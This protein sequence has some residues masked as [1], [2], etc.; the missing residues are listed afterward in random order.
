MSSLIE[1]DPQPV[2]SSVTLRLNNP[3]KRNALS[4]RMRDELSDALDR[5]AAD[6]SVKSVVIVGAGTSFCSGFDLGEFATAMGDP[7]FDRRLWESS[8]RFHHRLLSFPLPLFAAVN[9]AAIAGGFDLAICCDVRIAARSSRFSHP[10]FSYGDILYSP[11]REL[12]GGAV[13]RELALTG[14]ELSAREAKRLGVVNHVVAD[15]HLDEAIDELTV[16]TARA[17]R[18][19]LM[20]TK[21]KAIRSA[22]VQLRSTLDL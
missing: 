1:V 11:L 7:I 8:D 22:G 19:K 9:G 2:T 3:K 17:P 12:V 14:R 18:D 20:R 4:I 5:L 6:P 21:A 15:G 16:A 13:A 10:E